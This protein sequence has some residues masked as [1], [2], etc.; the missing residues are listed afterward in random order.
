ML[1]VWR[2]PFQH[3]NFRGEV[4]KAFRVTRY[5]RREQIVLVDTADDAVDRA[6]ALQAKPPGLEE[7]HALVCVEEL[8]EP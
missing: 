4:V 7:E 2:W 5:F 1:D 8:E 3:I 6:I